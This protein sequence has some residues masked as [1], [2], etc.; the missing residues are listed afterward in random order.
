MI[1]ALIKIYPLPGREHSVIEVLDSMKGPITALSDCLG[2]L[3][4]VETGE[5][6]AVCYME[7]WRTREALDRHLRSTLYGRVLEVM[8]RSRLPPEIEFFD[9]VRLGG[10][11]LLEAARS[12]APL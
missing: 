6:G 2:C 11:E 10:L 1:F 7:Q 12:R 4:L 8:E 9:A 5:G 3:V